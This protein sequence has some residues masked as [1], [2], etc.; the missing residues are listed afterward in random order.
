[1]E[2]GE[3]DSIDIYTELFQIEIT[4]STSEIGKKFRKLSLK[5]HPD[6][7]PDDRSK[8]LFL[9]F[10]SAFRFLAFLAFFCA[11]SISHSLA[12]Q[13]MRLKRAC[14]LLCDTNRRKAYDSK[15]KAKQMQLKRKAEATGESKKFRDS[16]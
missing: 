13:F 16:M 15:Q 1:M 2:E 11:P 12:E 14:D 3:F 5:C 10:F 8:G 4:A 7:F 6:L 9:F